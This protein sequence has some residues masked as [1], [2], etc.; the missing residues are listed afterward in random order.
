MIPYKN[1]QQQNKYR[2]YGWPHEV[3]FTD[4]SNLT[5]SNKVKVLNA[6]NNIYFAKN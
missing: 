1:W 6:L 2:L 4:Y 3:E 5:E